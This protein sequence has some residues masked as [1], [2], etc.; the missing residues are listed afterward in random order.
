[1]VRLGDECDYR[2]NGAALCWALSRFSAA[3]KAVDTGDPI[4]LL[5]WV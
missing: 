5:P 1:V 3:R 2:S 4:Y